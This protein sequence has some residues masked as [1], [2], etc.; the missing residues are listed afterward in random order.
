[1]NPN[2]PSRH[3]RYHLTHRAKI[4]PYVATYVELELQATREKEL[5]P[6]PTFSTVAL[7]PRTGDA[8]RFARVAS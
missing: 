1:M 2:K 6:V 4:L 8:I 5:G 3:F 7:D